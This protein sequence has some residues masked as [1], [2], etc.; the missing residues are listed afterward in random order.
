MENK[1]PLLWKINCRVLWK[2]VYHLQEYYDND[3]GQPKSSTTSR[4][5]ELLLGYWQEYNFKER[6]SNPQIDERMYQFIPKPRKST[7]RFKAELYRRF[8]TDSDI[9]R[10]QEIILALSTYTHQK[11]SYFTDPEKWLTGIQQW[12][13]SFDFPFNE[14]AYDVLLCLI[15]DKTTHDIAAIIPTYYDSEKGQP[16]P[17]IT[18]DSSDALVRYWREYIHKERLIDPCIDE[19][20][21]KTITMPE[22][23]PLL[24]YHS[25]KKPYGT[26]SNNNE[27]NQST[28]NIPEHVADIKE[29]QESIEISQTNSTKM[30]DGINISNGI[31]KQRTSDTKTK[32]SLDS[33]IQ[34]PRV[35]QE[36]YKN[37]NNSAESRNHYDICPK[38]KT[39]IPMNSTFCFMCGYKIEKVFCPDCGKQISLSEEACP[40][41]GYPIKEMLLPA[42]K[43]ES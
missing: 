11:Y 18:K 6:V 24:K 43:N 15:S 40:N 2:I 12:V 10:K 25:S 23:E 42:I 30:N 34:E 28:A 38:C 5:T 33:F 41:C 37:N 7:E 20:F 16:K 35:H 9:K 22:I 36:E 21:C 39:L 4:I 32:N 19:F 3:K 17:S 27:H 29:E 26:I 1:M 13:L 31:S 14:N 8:C